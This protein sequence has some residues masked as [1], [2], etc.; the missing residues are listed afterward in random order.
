MR[1]EIQTSATKQTLCPK[2]TAIEK[3]S[4]LWF[5]ISYFLNW[6]GGRANLHMEQ[7]GGHRLYQSHTCNLWQGYALPLCLLNVS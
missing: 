3:Q 5:S 7:V 4:F 1:A 2:P 6:V